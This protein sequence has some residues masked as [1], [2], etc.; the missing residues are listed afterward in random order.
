MGKKY[1]AESKKF[2]G[3]SSIDPLDTFSNACEIKNQKSAEL[4]VLFEQGIFFF[5]FAC[6][7]KLSDEQTF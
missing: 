5:F 6:K 4:N 3:D 2:E 7:S 1:S